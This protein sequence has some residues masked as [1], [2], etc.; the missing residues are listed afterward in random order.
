MAARGHIDPPTSDS[1]T[2]SASDTAAA[3]AAA[4]MASVA[5]A[6][7]VLGIEPSALSCACIDGDTRVVSQLLASRAEL[8]PKAGESP[9]IAAIAAGQTAVV[10]LLIAAG[11]M[12]APN[13]ELHP[14]LHVA[15]SLGHTEM[16]SML[17][18]AAADV[19]QV[20]ET[21]AIPLVVSSA[22][23]HVAI[24]SQLLLAR[25]AVNHRSTDDGYTALYAASQE[26]QAEVA[27]ELLK[28]GA[29]TTLS[30]HSDWTP[31]FIG[32]KEG[33]ADVVSVLLEAGASVDQ[34]AGSVTSLFIACATGQLTVAQVL[35]SYNAARD[36]K[37][38]NRMDSPA[39]LSAQFA[40]AR[41]ADLAAKHGH[42][43]LSEWLITSQ[44]WTTPLHYLDIIGAARARSL[45][46]GAAD[47]HA[48]TADGPTP[49]SLAL[50]MYEGG[51]EHCAGSEAASKGA[52][53]SAAYLVLQAS[54]PWSRMTHELFPLRARGRASAL[55]RIGQLLSHQPWFQ[56]GDEVRGD[57]NRQVA[58]LDVWIDHVIPL[59][60]QRPSGSKQKPKTKKKKKGP[61]QGPQ[62]V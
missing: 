28:A 21:G 19:N 8:S 2:T 38:V 17:L 50:E 4:A 15:G 5:A 43:E 16:V 12:T 22:K 41:A 18:A 25:A 51:G 23:G 45:L 34:A 47:L 53:G 52:K 14:P 36:L 32:S 59:A 61:Q 46:R 29:D 49:L 40:G 27:K 6:S 54:R 24:V 60:V 31:L 9:L 55:V 62:E 30:N 56:S 39:H 20:D 37:I 33:H 44:Q 26:G 42:R 35:C 3:V 7:D 58:L 10:E 13:A 1:R 57:N 11:A 48:G